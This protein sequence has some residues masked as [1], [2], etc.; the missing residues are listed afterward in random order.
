LCGYGSDSVE[1]MPGGQIINENDRDHGFSDLAVR[2]KIE[3]FSYKNLSSV[4]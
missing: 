3:F 2:Y 1:C 4:F